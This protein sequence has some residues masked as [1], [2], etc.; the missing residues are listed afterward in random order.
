MN[1]FNS[2]VSFNPSVYATLSEADVLKQIA[3]VRSKKND[4]VNFLKESG[5]DALAKTIGERIDNLKKIEDQFTFSKS[6]L[7]IP[8]KARKLKSDD[9][10]NREIDDQEL[11]DLWDNAQGKDASGKLFHIG[12][13]GWSMV[14]DI[15]K[16][17]GFDARPEVV[18]ED[19]YWKRI[20]KD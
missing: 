12:N 17:R 5:Q 15:A 16:L 19:E 9:E 1:T 4:I 7:N 20:G 14:S 10:M 11:K 18:T 8:I 13:L 6:L 2:I 3:E